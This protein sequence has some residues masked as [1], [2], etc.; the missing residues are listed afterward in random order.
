MSPKYKCIS[1]YNH[2]FLALLDFVSRAT[3]RRPSINSGFSETSAWIQAKFCGKLYLS[4][5]SP[6]C[7][8]FFQNFSFLNFYDF[9]FF[10]LLLTI[11]T[12]SIRFHPNFMKI[13]I[14][15]GEYRLLQPVLFLAICQKLKILWHNFLLTQDHMGLEISKRLTDLLQF[16]SDVSQTLWGHWLP[17]WNTGYHFSWQSAKF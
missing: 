3:V 5:I 17:W 7:F 11:G 6:D 13:I 9:F 8:F 4:T 1:L 14:V 12:I 2:P 10:W 16:S 15:M